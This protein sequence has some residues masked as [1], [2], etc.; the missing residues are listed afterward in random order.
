MPTRHSRG[1]LLTIGILACS[2]LI[3]SSVT[4][5]SPPIQL[6]ACGADPNANTRALQTAID[7]AAPGSTLV[8]APGECVLAKCDLARGSICY[9]ANGR[10]H[11]S[12]LNFGNRTALTLAGADD[13]T[14]VLKLDPT[15][16]RDANGYHAYCGDTHVVLINGSSFV[17]LRGFTI[18]GSDG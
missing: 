12:A 8:L 1:A 16:P 17:S 3:A 4:A 11:R 9:G 2:L 7:N 5:Q 10:P 15:P 18:D 6:P 14:S 13:G